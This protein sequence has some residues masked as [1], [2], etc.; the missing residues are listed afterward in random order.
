MLKK[1]D[2]KD[3]VKFVWVNNAHDYLMMNKN[4]ESCHKNL[5]KINFHKI[6]KL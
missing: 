3:L 5:N 1:E 4:N 2:Y 6:S